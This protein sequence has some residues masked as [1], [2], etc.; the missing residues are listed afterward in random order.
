MHR[1]SA[2]DLLAEAT[3]VQAGELTLCAERHERAVLPTM[4]TLQ[5][6]LVG[7]VIEGGDEFTQQ[8]HFSTRVREA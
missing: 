2:R 6:L 5:Q 3:D 8:C 7:D 4:Q 1:L